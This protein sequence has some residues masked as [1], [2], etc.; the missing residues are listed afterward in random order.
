MRSATTRDPR[1]QA[2]PCP[3]STAARIWLAPKSFG[4]ALTTLADSALSS[5]SFHHSGLATSSHSSRVSMSKAHA[6]VTAQS[7]E[8][9]CHRS[10]ASRNRCA[11]STACPE[12]LSAAPRLKYASGS[13]GLRAMASRQQLLVLVARLRGAPGLLLRGLAIPL[14]H[15]PAILRH[16]PMPLHLLVI[17]RVPLPRARVPR[18]GDAA[19]VRCRHLQL[20]ANRANFVLLP[21]VAHL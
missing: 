3:L 4:A 9:T 18:A 12:L 10:L 20:D 17:H 2:P 11:A 1:S 19:P 14:L 13:S 21:V 8:P 7:S 6:V 5:S 15:D 16:L